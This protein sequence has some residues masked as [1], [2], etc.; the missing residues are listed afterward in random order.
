MKSNLKRCIPILLL[1]IFAVCLLTSCKDADEVTG[2][3]DW[4]EDVL[5]FAS[6]YEDPA[7]RE[8]VD[9]FNSTHTDVQI[10]VRDYSGEGGLS[11]LTTEI[12]AGKIPDII[13]LQLMPCR[14]LAL[15]GYLGG[16]VALY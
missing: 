12:L 7:W 2:T 3:F 10:E 16:S 9:E 15:G 5:V 11:R 6:L 14:Q 1:S 13:D 4:D 8:S